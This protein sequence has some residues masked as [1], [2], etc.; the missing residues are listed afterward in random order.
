MSAVERAIAGGARPVP[1]PSVE[2]PLLRRVTRTWPCEAATCARARQL[3]GLKLGAWGAEEKR[4]GLADAVAVTELLVSELVTN[5][6]LHTGCRWLGLDLRLCGGLVRVTVLDC[7]RE[8]PMVI[9]AGD[10]DVHGRG[11][12]LV[13]QLSVRWGADLMPRGKAVWCEV[14]LGPAA[15][16]RASA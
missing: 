4:R 8:L 9:P 13:D 2:Q 3:V 7:S 6:I 1:P 10:D 16:R 11:L 15:E 12:A 5:A 14:R